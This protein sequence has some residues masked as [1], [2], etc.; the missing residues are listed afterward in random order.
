MAGPA[1]SSFQRQLLERFKGVV[2]ITIVVGAGLQVWPPVLVIIIVACLADEYYRAVQQQIFNLHTWSEPVLL[3]SASAAHAGTGAVAEA[4]SGNGNPGGVGASSLAGPGSSPSM[5]QGASSPPIA[6]LPQRAHKLGA[7]KRA[8]YVAMCVVISLSALVSHEC[9]TVTALLLSVSLLAFLMFHQVEQVGTRPSVPVATRKDKAKQQQ[10]D[11]N[12]AAAPLPAVAA[13]SGCSYGNLPNPTPSLLLQANSPLAS[14]HEFL[15]VVVLLFGLWYTGFLFSH[16]LLILTHPSGFLR[17]AAV[18][19][20]AA[21]NRVSAAMSSSCGVARVL[22][23]I[24]VTAGGE[25]GG[26]FIGRAL[27][28]VKFTPRLSP[29]KSREGALAQ[30][31]T[32]MIVSGL[33]ARWVAVDLSDA[34]ALFC[35]LL[36][37]VV[38]TLGDLFESFLKRSVGV[39]DLGQIIP[40]A[41]GMADRMDGLIF[42]FPAFYYF[43]QFAH[44][45][46]SEY[47]L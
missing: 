24:V 9:L 3:Q 22:Y 38:A 39:K 28:R 25:N 14:A 18:T 12:A 41:G 40:G 46:T 5:S 30:L 13:A 43:L 19:V 37:G 23:V 17:S 36:I 42:S 27:G 16:G 34:E 7:R 8:V 44:S 47:G 29:N 26:M 1:L 20:A 21:S 11:A 32:S 10:V 4:K 31:L 35:G 15:A 33:F 45:P 6:P 2:I